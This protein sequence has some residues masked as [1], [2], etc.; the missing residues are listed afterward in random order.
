MANFN[1]RVQSAREKAATVNHEGYPAF[2]M[3]DELKLVTQVLTSFVG[4][5]KFYGD[6]TTEMK[7]L[8]LKVIGYNPEFVSKL[9]VYARR[10]FNMRSVSHLLTAL[11]AHEMSGKPYARRTLNGVAL[12]GDD[13]TEVAACYMSL[14]QGEPFPASLKK[15]VKD[16]MQGFD[17]YTLAKYKG[18]GKSVTMKDLICLCHPKPINS[19]Q[20][21]MFKR[22]LEGTLKVPHTWETEL[23]TRGNTKEV[24]EELIDSGDVG[25]MAKLRNLRNIINA[26]PDNID[27][28]Y[29]TLSD[30]KAVRKSRQL[31]FRFLAAYKEIYRLDN[32]SSRALDTLESAVISSVSNMEHLP[33]R[34]VIA[35]DV[36]GSMGGS[37]STRSKIRYVEVGYLLGM[38]ANRICDDCIFYTF[39]HDIKKVPVSKHSNVLDST[40]RAYADGGTDMHLPFAKM[41]QDGVKAD[42]VIIFSDSECNTPYRS[43]P[44]QVIADE[45]R[46][47]SGNNIW[48]HAVDLAGYGTTQFF[49]GRT[50]SVAGW[51]EKLFELF[52]LA[53]TRDKS[54]DEALVEEVKNFSW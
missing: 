18:A 32:V 24:W 23:S 54:M 9:A 34:T 29:Q 51:S 53:E 52:R 1:K 37:L 40:C 14:F 33:G 36:S 6:N 50:N 42:R 17:E 27:V 8:A 45:Y 7:E 35:V 38:L 10:V 21:A 3:E 5:S 11:L 15:G 22:C 19:E 39:N 2:A 44:V 43:E 12:R 28:V 13:I 4:E 26:Q 47:D 31:P 16:V 30:P 20:E 41:I 46:R 25:Y 48:V 49:G